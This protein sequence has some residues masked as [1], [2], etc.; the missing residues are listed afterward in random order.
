M[1][2]G[3]FSAVREFTASLL[4]ASDTTNPGSLTIGHSGVEILRN[5]LAELYGSPVGKLPSRTVLLGANVTV[6]DVEECS[7]ITIMLTLPEESDP[8]AGRLSVLSPLGLALLGAR[9][10]D[11]VGF[12]L[13]GR[14]NRSF[15]SHV[16]T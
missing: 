11:A 5:K 7:S 9:Q 15:V 1:V 12:Y 3:S 14:Y 10:G 13:G 8:S 16:S 4:A 6:I 2:S